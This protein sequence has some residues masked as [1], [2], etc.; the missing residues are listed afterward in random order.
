M[1]IICFKC[2]NLVKKSTPKGFTTIC[3]VDAGKLEDGTLPK[4]K[5]A[6]FESVEQLRLTDEK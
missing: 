5:C 3:K 6:K 1:I 4:T 2:K